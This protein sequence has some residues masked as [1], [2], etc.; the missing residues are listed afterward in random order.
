MPINVIGHACISPMSES[1]HLSL[2]N[3]QK[4][5]QKQL[6]IIVLAAGASSRLGQPKQLVEFA[7]K[8]LLLR[9]CELALQLSSEVVCVL[10][11]QADIMAERL[12]DLAINLV[13]NENWQ[14]GM[15]SSIA[16]GIAA[17]PRHIDAAM[18]LLVDQWQLRP[19]SLRLFEQ[20]WREKPEKITLAGMS[21]TIKSETANLTKQAEGASEQQVIKTGPPVIFPRFFFPDLMALTGTSGAKPLLKNHQDKLNMVNLSAAFIDLD[22]PEQLAELRLIE[23]GLF[24]VTNND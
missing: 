8:S 5:R 3:K 17:L 11:C 16:A 24:N 19:A 20:N 9:Q 10:G 6:A 1:D 15:S 21:R 22:T 23:Q 7:G 14:Q 18:I 12:Q 13:I 2:H 4:V